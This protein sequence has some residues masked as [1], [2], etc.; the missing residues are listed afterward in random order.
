MDLREIGEFGL[1]EKIKQVVDT[2]AS[3][4]LLLGIGDDC[5]AFKT[6]GDQVLLLTTDVLIEG[7]HFNLDYFD[8]YNIGHRAMASNL[9]DIAAMGGSP[10]Y[11]L[12]AL[13][14]RSDLPVEAVRD[15]YL[16]MNRLAGLF[17]VA[18]IGGDTARS[19]DKLF[20][21]V[22]IF[23]EASEDKLITR[24][25]ARIG[26]TIFVTGDLGGAQAGLKIL[27][28]GP[29]LNREF[30]KTREKHLAPAPRIDE[31]KF[32]VSEYDIHS[33][34]DISDGLSSE[35]HHICR[36]S[37]MGAVLFEQSIPIDLE[38]KQVADTFADEALDYALEG[39]EDFELLFTA[40]GAVAAE[41]S[42][43]FR[44]R[45]GYDCTAI[46]EIKDAST[47][48]VLAFPDGRHK[49]LTPASYDHFRK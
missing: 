15:L 22:T 10:K 48:V 19:S 23:G 33:M 17:Q 26:D 29:P 14:L 13:G 3:G 2:T 35:I 11:A 31:S 36:G 47:G 44:D 32:L 46:G 38:T 40:P 24:S 12:V 25:G 21:A 9:S 1:I 39:G 43:G 42:R 28:N 37:G 6:S 18:I 41:L 30:S 7:V 4:D 5:A 45:F 27:M 34:I 16:G 8:F 20:V 49:T